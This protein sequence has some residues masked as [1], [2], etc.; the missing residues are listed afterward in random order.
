MLAKCGWSPFDERRFRSRVVTTLVNGEVGF[1]FG[2]S[3][4]RLSDQVRGQRLSVLRE[5]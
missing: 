5:R 2:A 3:G 1:E 4:G